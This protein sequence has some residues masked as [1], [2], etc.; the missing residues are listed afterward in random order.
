MG[1]SKGAQE[2]SETFG[3]VESQISDR[4]VGYWTPF[5]DYELGVPRYEAVVGEHKVKLSEEFCGGKDADGEVVAD[6]Y[7]CGAV[8][9]SASI[10]RF[11]SCSSRPRIFNRIWS[12]RHARRTFL[13]PEIRR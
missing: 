3:I 8:A 4:W 7:F 11:L 10:V 13:L 5:L 6:G 9:D 2:G 12:Y 1:A